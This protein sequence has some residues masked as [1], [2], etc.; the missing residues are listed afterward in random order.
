MRS[1]NNGRVAAIAAMA[2][3]AAWVVPASVAWGQATPPPIGAK[4]DGHYGY[5]LPPDVSTHGSQIDTLIDV[6][7]WFMAALFVGWAIFLVRCLMKYR[8]RPG[9]TANYNLIKAKPAKAVEVAVIV[10]E[11]ILLV[12]MS[13]PVWAQLKNDLP[14]ASDNPIRVRVVAE[15]FAWN[16]HYPGPDGVFGKTAP[17]FVNLATNPVGVD[18]NDPDGKDDIQAKE[19]HI[20]VGRPVICEVSSKDVIHSF[21]LPVARVKQ[22]TIPGMRIPVWFKTRPGTEGNYEVACAQLCGNNHYSMK[23]LMVIESEEKFKAWLEKTGT[24]E[25]FED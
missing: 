19:F 6:L 25:V 5:W 3:V 21:F 18:E 24:K 9:H 11:V 20:P 4:I 16:F 22:D 1:G 23:A 17:K 8:Q 10:V 13:M 7:H 2:F 15:Q 12:G 14:A